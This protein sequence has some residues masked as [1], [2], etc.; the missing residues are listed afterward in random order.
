MFPDA[1]SIVDDAASNFSINDE[2]ERIQKAESLALLRYFP[3]F[4]WRE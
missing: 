4:F 2:M 1:D 3:E